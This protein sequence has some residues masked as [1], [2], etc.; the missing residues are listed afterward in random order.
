MTR[1]VPPGGHADA[2]EPGAQP[3]KKGRL[4][5]V[6]LGLA[7]RH[8]VLRRAIGIQVVYRSTGG[9]LIVGGL[10]YAALFALIPTLILVIAGIFW[11]VDDPVFRQQAIVLINEA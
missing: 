6:A 2:P 10:S 1:P 3:R 8:A 9:G 5:T 11:L 7:M 4:K